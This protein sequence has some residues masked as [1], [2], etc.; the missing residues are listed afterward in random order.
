MFAQLLR[1][2]RRLGSCIA[3]QLSVFVLLFVA[4]G[5]GSA[6][7]ETYSSADQPPAKR[8]GRALGTPQCG[9]YTV[10]LVLELLRQ[11]DAHLPPAA[12]LR[13]AWARVVAEADN[14]NRLFEGSPTR[15]R[16]LRPSYEALLATIDRAAAA[17]RRGDAAT[18]RSLIDHAGP[19]VASVS[20]AASRA[21]LKCTIKSSTDSSTLT[22]GG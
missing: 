22:F 1:A 20:S 9:L 3:L 6:R 18:F 2:Q 15:L 11:H 12:K 13:P 5:C 16:G 17:L 14:A 8:A 19:T 7:S 10:T 4:A 21:H